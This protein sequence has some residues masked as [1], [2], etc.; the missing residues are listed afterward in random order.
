MIVR[1]FARGVVLL[2]V[3]GAVVSAVLFAVLLF[4]IRTQEPTLLRGVRSVN[5]QVWNKRAIRNAGEPGV[6]YA[7]VEHRGRSSGT[8]YTTPIDAIPT[9]DGFVVVL[10]YGTQADWVRNVLHHGEA[11]IVHDGERV[12]V[13]APVLMHPRDVDHCFSP[14]ARRTNRLFGIERCLVVRRRD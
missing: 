8:E 5:K 7:K 13:H 6:G 4:A 9:D 3:V 10:P 14:G 11:V 2:G 1:L 12:E